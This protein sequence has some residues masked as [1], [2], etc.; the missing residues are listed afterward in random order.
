MTVILLSYEPHRSS[1]LTHLLNE[2]VDVSGVVGLLLEDVGAGPDPSEQGVSL[3][4]LAHF[5]ALLDHVVPVSVLHHLVQRPVHRL[6]LVLPIE[7][8]LFRVL[9][10]LIDDFFSVFV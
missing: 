8:H 7:L 10:D 5:D 3:F 2:V 6:P 1:L 9:H 4:A